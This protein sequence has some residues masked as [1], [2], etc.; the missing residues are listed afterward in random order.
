M[1][2]GCSLFKTLIR[3]FTTSKDISFEMEA[4]EKILRGCDLLADAVQL[5][6][7]PKGRNFKDNKGWS[8][9][10]KGNRI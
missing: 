6:L 10:S 8:G 2:T 1:Q 9:S 4:K 5:T 7:G 3:A